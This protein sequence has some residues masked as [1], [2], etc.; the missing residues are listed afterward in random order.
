MAFDDAV[1]RLA[2]LA[3]ADPQRAIADEHERWRLYEE[4]LRHVNRRAAVLEAVRH[5]GNSR[6][7]SAV[8]IRALELVPDD[9]RSSWVEVVP[10]GNQRDFAAGRARE[11]GLVEELAREPGSHVREADLRGWSP[12]LQLRLSG[13][14]T[15]TDVLA[16]LAEHGA[17]RRIRTLARRRL[18]LPGSSS[19]RS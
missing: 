16:L 14:V 10:A 11:L 4:S 3:G 6:L 5:D 17:T 12:W 2:V 18:G 9:Q 7:V 8:V 13:Q 15:D 19:A 1:G